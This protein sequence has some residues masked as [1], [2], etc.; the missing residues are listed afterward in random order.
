MIQSALDRIIY[1]EFLR[2]IGRK[3]LKIVFGAFKSY[4]IYDISRNLV[5]PGSVFFQ[6]DPAG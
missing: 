6:S 4:I 5:Q 3:K 2:C 1:G